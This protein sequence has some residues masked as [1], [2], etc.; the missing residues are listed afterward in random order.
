MERFGF[1]GKL[2]F[3]ICLAIFLFAI[4]ITSQNAIAATINVNST[5][6]RLTPSD[7]NCTIREAINNANSNSDTS[8]GDCTAGAFGADIIVI[9]AGTYRIALNGPGDDANL[10]GDFD[11]TEGIVIQ[12]LQGAEATIQG[13][14]NDRVFDFQLGANTHT[15]RDLIV[16]GGNA[17][18]GV[19]DNDGGGIRGRS[20]NMLFF[21]RITVTENDADNDGGGIGCVLCISLTIS[22]STFFKNIA[23]KD[24]SGS[25]DGGGIFAGMQS[26]GV[27]NL[28]DSTL[29]GDTS[30]SQ[31]PDKNTA[32]NGG[33]VAIANNG[34]I[35]VVRTTISGNEATNDGGGFY[36]TKNDF[37]S[38]ITNSTIS[39]NRA[40][41]DGGGV[42]INDGSGVTPSLS[43]R[44]TTI[45]EN[46]ADSDN[47][48]TGD[49]G[50]ISNPTNDSV[51]LANVILANNNDSSSR[52]DCDGNI[53]PSTL[54]VPSIIGVNSGCEA[55][56]PTGNPNA[57]GSFVGTEAAPIDPKLEPL[58]IIVPGKTA[59]HLLKG[60]SPAIDEGIN[61]FC[62]ATPVDA[63][64]Q[65]GIA[66]PQQFN[67]VA[68]CDI[69]SVELQRFERFNATQTIRVSQGYIVPFHCGEER[70]T[71][72]NNGDKVDSIE[73]S[74]TLITVLFPEDRISTNPSER[75]QAQIVQSATINAHSNFLS[76][77]A[78]SVFVL[79]TL[80]PGKIY[81]LNC[82]DIKRQPV[83][84][85]GDG[86]I[87]STIADAQSTSREFFQGV[88]N[89]QGTDSLEIHVKKIKRVWF[90]V[91]D[92]AGVEFKNG[93]QVVETFDIEGFRSSG[94]RSVDLYTPKADLPS[95]AATMQKT[96]LEPVNIRTPSFSHRALMGRTSVLFQAQGISASR[97]DV[98]VFSLT[99]SKVYSGTA[100]GNSLRWNLKSKSGLPLANGIYLYVIKIRGPDGH[101]IRSSVKKLVVLR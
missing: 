30:S 83:S 52:P 39:G 71:F 73:L 17:V 33:G 23:D 4:L 91:P 96:N 89:L 15:M 58:A 48:G 84:F 61:T 67:G 41:N 101:V 95:V 27:F 6:D 19:G 10:S 55:G 81:R 100:N 65:R 92:G 74:E 46:T 70:I 68:Q 69:G 43:I 18:N 9:P 82:E 21:E 35:R 86:S 62:N 51:F 56:F 99:G 63:E 93:K 25:G 80:N 14:N 85:N 32:F 26:A 75:D 42:F 2:R 60:D 45:T 31:L 49:G 28:T 16:K 20:N 90:G 47:N 22:D 78:M 77:G 1:G 44:S 37:Q 29:G 72:R 87:A 57:N 59:V 12:G 40:K 8:G 13:P 97:F 79:A 34:L 24:K 76:P 88:L 53:T 38:R 36:D 50:G 11:I 54:G 94:S 66:R 98:E 7:G 64:D 3:S 5:M